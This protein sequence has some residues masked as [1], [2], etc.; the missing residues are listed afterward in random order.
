MPLA[1]CPLALWDLPDSPKLP[2]A[3]GIVLK[4]KPIA[5]ATDGTT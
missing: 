1:K 2:L 3:D 5:D 4:T